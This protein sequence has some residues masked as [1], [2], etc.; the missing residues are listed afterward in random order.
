MPRPNSPSVRAS[1]IKS[2]IEWPPKAVRG[3]ATT[4]STP[5]IKGASDKKST[6]RLFAE[7]KNSVKIWYR[8]DYLVG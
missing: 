4:Q 6:L 2:N 8:I 3:K 7:N 5:E 1:Q